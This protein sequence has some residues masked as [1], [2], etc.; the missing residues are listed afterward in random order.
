VQGGKL[1]VSIADGKVYLIDAKGSKVMVE[2]ADV[3]AENGVVHIIGGVLLP[4]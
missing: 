1:T 3:G 4:S 2:T